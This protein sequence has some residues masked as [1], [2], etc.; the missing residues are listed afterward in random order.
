MIL[1]HSDAV[2]LNEKTEVDYLAYCQAHRKQQMSENNDYDKNKHIFP[3]I[4][5]TYI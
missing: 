5:S 3:L 2:K 1:Q 4:S